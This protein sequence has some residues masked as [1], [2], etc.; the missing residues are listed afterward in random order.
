MLTGPPVTLSSA[1]LTSE[2]V[3]K[4]V[5][6]QRTQLEAVTFDARTLTTTISE[7]SYVVEPADRF[8][9]TGSICKPSLSTYVET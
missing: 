9:E 5:Q 3:A 1:R 6:H 2:Q 7:R 8:M 4:W